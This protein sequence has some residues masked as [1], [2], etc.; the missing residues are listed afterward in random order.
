MTVTPLSSQP[1]PDDRHRPARPILAASIAVFREGRVLIARRA[2]AP[3]AGAYSLPGGVVEL[4]ETL[5]EAALR[6]LKEEVGVE[7]E[8][9]AFIDHVEPIAREGAN[10]REHYVVAAFV[11]RW[12]RGEARPGA[13][14][15]VVVWI[16]P[17][18][19]GAY[20]TTPNLPAIIAKAAALER[21]LK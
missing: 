11:G 7:A 1:R 5:R 19:I 16:D 21:T 12:R 4:G 13:E 20:S 9:L 10:V 8:I 3:M 2:R 15:D 18:A 17:D 14:A 6:E